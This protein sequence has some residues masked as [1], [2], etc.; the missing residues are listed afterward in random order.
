MMMSL[1]IEA[2]QQLEMPLTLLEACTWFNQKE[3]DQRYCATGA[4]YS[5]TWK[6]N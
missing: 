1:L 6:T 5:S 4:D 2:F 3:R